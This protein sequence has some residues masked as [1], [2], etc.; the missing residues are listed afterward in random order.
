MIRDDHEDEATRARH[1][2]AAHALGRPLRMAVYVMPP[3]PMDSAAPMPRPVRVAVP[4]VVAA[5]EN[6]AEVRPMSDPHAKAPYAVEWHRLLTETDAA[7]RLATR[8]EQDLVAQT[9]PAP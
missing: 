7:P 3:W 9:W 1:A 8:D 2:I 6:H 5:R 4:V